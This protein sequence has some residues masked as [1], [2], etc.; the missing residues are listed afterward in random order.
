M[1]VQ[2]PRDR[3]VAEEKVEK[4]SEVMPQV[5]I[6]ESADAPPTEVKPT[7][8]KPKKKTRKKRAAK[9]ETPEVGA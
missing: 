6:R 5:T 9:K 2:S 4:S 8:E 3:T 1:A 7:E